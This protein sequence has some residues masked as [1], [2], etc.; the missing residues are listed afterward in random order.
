MATL[1]PDI[2]TCPICQEAPVRVG[3]KSYYC[4]NAVGTRKTCTFF[5]GKEIKSCLIHE[6]EARRLIETGKSGLIKGFYSKH[7]NPFSAYL[8][9]NETGWAFAFPSRPVRK[10]QPKGGSGD[11]TS[12]IA[13]A[14]AS[15]RFRGP[16]TS[17][18]KE[19]M[20]P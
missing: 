14:R 13:R 18:L 6:S 16:S 9:I 20:D 15:S 4:S 10:K 1:H 5:L 7:G 8:V 12:E 3:P 19:M 2:G 17:R 11:M